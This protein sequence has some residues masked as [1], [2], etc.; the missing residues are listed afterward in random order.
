MT[1]EQLQELT[2]LYALGALNGDEV[3][4]LQSL[5]QANDPVAIRMQNQWLR[6][7]TDAALHSQE[8]IPPPT[9]VKQRLMRAIQEKHA[10]ERSMEGPG[11][12]HIEHAH[13]IVSVFPEHVEWQKH[14]VPGV[15]FKVL[16]ENKRRG[17]V[18]MLMKVEPGTVFPEHHHSGDEECYILRGSI[19]LDGKRL[20][21][22]VFHH[23][24]ENSEHGTLTSDEGALLLLVVAREDYIHPVSP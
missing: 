10:A 5:L 8:P 3:R 23:G 12:S 16:S 15:S 24:D 2:I 17:Y 7:V 22:G 11:M 20:G 4:A 13:G 18:T 19:I 21:A 6:V 14:P 1:P 9:H